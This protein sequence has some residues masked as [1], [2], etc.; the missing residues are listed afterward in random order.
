MTPLVSGVIGVTLLG[1]VLTPPILIGGAAT[2]AG[3]AIVAL[4]ERRRK[5]AALA[6]T[7]PV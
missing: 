5:L 7:D 4:A 1:D 2:L 6:L 3:V